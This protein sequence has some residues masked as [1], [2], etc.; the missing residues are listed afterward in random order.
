MGAIDV[1]EQLVNDDF[2]QIKK[3][4]CWALSN[5]IST[6]ENYAGYLKLNH[7]QLIKSLIHMCSDN[8][9]IVIF[10]NPRLERK[11]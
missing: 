1:L 2:T 8:S 9:F 5:F 4:A 3:E 6:G 10:F 11:L 7:P